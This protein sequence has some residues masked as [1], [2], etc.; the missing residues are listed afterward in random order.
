MDHIEEH[1]DSSDISTDEL[2]RKMDEG[3]GNEEDYWPPEER[4]YKFPHEHQ[5]T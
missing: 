4:K 3:M 1:K 5:N 2:I